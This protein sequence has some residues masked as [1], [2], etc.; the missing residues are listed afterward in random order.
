MSFGGSGTLPNRFLGYELGIHEIYIYIS[1]DYHPSFEPLEA[2][3]S[4]PRSPC[5][6]QGPGCPRLPAPRPAR[7]KNPRP[8]NAGLAMAGPTSTGTHRLW[9]RMFFSWRSRRAVALRSGAARGES[10]A[11]VSSTS[12]KAGNTSS[13]VRLTPPGL[14]G[15]PGDLRA[16]RLGD[17]RVLLERAQ[18]TVL[19]VDSVCGL[20]VHRRRPLPRLRPASGLEGGVGPVEDALDVGQ[21]VL[22]AS[23]LVD[24][25]LVLDLGLIRQRIDHTA[26]RNCSRHL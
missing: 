9:S 23:R 11:P 8:Q 7:F 12:S 1:A 18:H 20:D 22:L 21:Y 6:V 5:S 4:A 3:V 2:L 14:M 10:G 19:A 25:V 26:S 13:Q 17:R 15:H 24:L 16:E